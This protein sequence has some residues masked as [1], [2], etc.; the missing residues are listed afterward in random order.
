MSF[1]NLPA[2][3]WPAPIDLPG[4]PDV[5][6]WSDDLL[7][8]SLRPWLTDV[9]ERTQCP[10]EYAAVGAIVALASVVGRGV[11]IRPKRQDD[12]TV[13][14]NLWGAVV[15]PPSAMKTPA[16]REAMRPLT[17]L[18]SQSSDT[19]T[20]NEARRMT[21]EA[22]RA[23]LRDAMKAAAKK[24]VVAISVRRDAQQE[25]TELEQQYDDLVAEAAEATAERRYIIY[26]ATVEKLGE[27]L[28]QSP[29]GVLLFRDE[30]VGWLRSLDKSGH[31]NDRSFFLE[32]WNGDGNYVYDRIARGTIK[33]ESA[34]VSI[35]GGIQPGPLGAYLR[36]AESGG[37]GDDGLM[38]RLQMLVYPDPP[39]GWINVDRWPDPEARQR[40]RDVYSRLANA[41]PEDLGADVLDG[42]PF[43]RFDESAQAYFETWRLNLEN[44]I[45]G[46]E[47][48]AA[49]ESHLTKYRSL[50]PSLALVLHL[51]DNAGGPVCLAASQRAAAW[52]Q[53]LEGHMRRVY[54]SVAQSRISGARAILGRLRAGKLPTPF[55]ARDVYRAQW[56]GLSEPAEVATAI[57]SLMEYG[58]LRKE[59]AATGGRPREEF[60]V[61]PDLLRKR[62]TR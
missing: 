41:T 17:H 58:W 28:S 23:A 26:D 22:K 62:G 30:L 13:V 11:A 47:E 10:P 6:T 15:G 37:A 16:L 53:L 55:V 25:Q 59:T 9:A 34:C 27:I 57:E 33:I 49:I 40:A 20:A 1:V 14:P 54:A 39:K 35:L 50:M 45:R 4:L 29:R 8:D 21:I 7:P 2:H 56:A 19:H 61:H 52:C 36:A 44:R 51:A 18:A 46:T 24:P 42:I 48:H 5:P 31:E 3:D 60:H 12:W 32:A 43:V 38:Q